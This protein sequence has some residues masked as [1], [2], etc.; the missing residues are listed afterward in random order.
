MAPTPLVV[1][2]GLAPLVGIV[3]GGAV[4]L[5]LIILIPT[6][7]ILRRKH[8]RALRQ[9]KQNATTELKRLSSTSGDNEHHSIPRISVIPADAGNAK[10]DTLASNENLRDEYQK[11]DRKK[12]KSADLLS[13]P[14]PRR[15]S[16]RGNDGAQR[17][18]QLSAISEDDHRKSLLGAKRDST[19]PATP[20]TPK[21]AHSPPAQIT[22]S[23]ALKPLPLF[24]GRDGRPNLERSFSVPS[25]LSA[26]P[27]L[28]ISQPTN[29]AMNRDSPIRSFSLTNLGMQLD[30]ETLPPLPALPAPVAKTQGRKN[31]RGSAASFASMSSVG[32][33]ASSILDHAN[34]P[35]AKSMMIFGQG[36]PQVGLGLGDIEYKQGASLDLTSTNIFATSDARNAAASNRH[37]LGQVH[38]V[39]HIRL[40]R[41]S[42][43]P[44]PTQI[45]AINTPKR[46]S[47]MR[48]ASY[49]GSPEDKEQISVFREVSGN[50]M[51]PSREYSTTSLLTIDSVASNPF[52]YSPTPP[53]SMPSQPRL[54]SALKRSGLGSKKLSQSKGSVRVLSNPTACW[55]PFVDNSPSPRQ[56]QDIREEVYED[57]D[58]G[59]IGS[60]PSPATEE[61]DEGFDDDDEENETPIPFP[62]PKDRLKAMSYTASLNPTSP[63]LSMTGFEE[64]LE[65]DKRGSQVRQSVASSVISLSTLPMPSST[66]WSRNVD[67]NSNRSDA[68]SSPF[69]SNPDSPLIPGLTLLAQTTPTKNT[70]PFPTI[71][72]ES[73]QLNFNPPQHDASPSQGSGPALLATPQNSNWSARPL[74][75]SSPA[76]MWN[77]KPEFIAPRPAPA[78]PAS[79]LQPNRLSGPRAA[80]A[81]STMTFVRSLR[82]ENSDVKKMFGSSKEVRRFARMGREQSPNLSNND[83][84]GTPP[85]MKQQ[86][87]E[88][89]YQQTEPEEGDLSTTSFSVWEDGAHPEWQPASTAPTQLKVMV[90]EVKGT[91]KG[92][93]RMGWTGVEDQ[94]NREVLV[95]SPLSH[96]HVF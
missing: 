76:N 91:P 11:S 74:S 41:I 1:P 30:S 81:K 40:N 32:T 45:R 4:I 22:P 8:Q 44:T 96:G 23:F 57:D 62:S 33:T 3:V 29:K 58:D 55:Y 67:H 12:R 79:L 24:S 66:N 39:E 69:A 77:T 35:R 82:R 56:M 94:E 49:C 87:Q 59:D 38:T 9:H 7:V 78:P 85:D 65:A 93:K 92:Q 72:L 14:L 46:D 31:Q 89:D 26:S 25:V 83:L 75:V 15:L 5:L 63:T 90:E 2:F 51:M 6:I 13:W 36:K 68:P 95:E 71:E 42:A 50:S 54:K 17:S 18:S 19:T 10:Y 88:H 34:S 37:S 16:R 61:F 53:Q 73:N 80:P 64:D 43:S 21:A 27:S 60:S 48:K 20:G 86:Q 52:Q 84:F 47:H 70:L 28:S